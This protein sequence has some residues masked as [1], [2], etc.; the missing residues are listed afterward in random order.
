MGK[1]AGF[2][3]IE[4][5]KF[6]AVSSG[7]D[8]WENIFGKNG[9]DNWLEE[10]KK[11]IREAFPYE[12]CD[13]AWHEE[14][15]FNWIWSVEDWVTEADTSPYKL[16]EFEGGMYV[17]GIADEND[18]TDCGE[19]YNGLIKWIQDS[20]VFESDDRPGHRIIFHRIGCGKIQ[21]ILGMAQ[22]EMFVPIKIK[23]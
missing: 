6:K 9:F 4:I 11:M 19:V 8:T 18:E 2:K 22:Q 7:L 13:F 10:H 14:D 3:V 1:L 20:N 17:V 21:E 16:I 15:K 12:G 5:P 23:K